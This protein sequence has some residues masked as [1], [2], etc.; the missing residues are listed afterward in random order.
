M[1]ERHSRAA[2]RI[3]ISSWLFELVYER[4]W[5]E[6]CKLAGVR[7]Y[8]LEGNAHSPPR[9]I[10]ERGWIEIVVFEKATAMASHD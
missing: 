2:K 3:G 7:E 1:G 4:I 6:C 10:H 9:S 5:T 8:I